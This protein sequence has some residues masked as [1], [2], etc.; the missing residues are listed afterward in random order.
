[1]MVLTFND[2]F[3]IIKKR[4]VQLAL[5]Y[6]VLLNTGPVKNARSFLHL[7]A[8]NVKR[9]VVYVN[10]SNTDIIFVALMGWEGD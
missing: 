5:Q 9:D 4:N 3:T 2:V 8:A 10:V 6:I 1:M 7:Y